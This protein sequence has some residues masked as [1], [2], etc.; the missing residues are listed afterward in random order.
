MKI[1][2]AFAS[3]YGTTQKCADMLAD[4]IQKQNYEVVTVDLQK[5]LKIKVDDFDVVVIGGS[6]VM[7]RMNK[8]VQKFVSLN[9]KKLLN[10]KIGIFMCG[11]DEKWQEE[12][13][14]GF[15]K[16]LLDHAS[17][18]GYFGYEL[19]LEKM[20][21]IARGMMKYVETPNAGIRQDNIEKFATEITI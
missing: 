18:R 17:T 13:K 21:G 8:F 3:R 5:S 12:L 1:L 9:L 11:M 10:K 4:L 14:K 2:I 19:N 6:F 15:P 7:G 16:S 20:S